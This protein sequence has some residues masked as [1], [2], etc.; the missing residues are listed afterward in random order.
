MSQRKKLIQSLVEGLSKSCIEQNRVLEELSA[1]IQ[2][3]DPL[4]EKVLLPICL[5]L[6]MCGRDSYVDASLLT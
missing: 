5:L 6:T 2:R 1:D 4:A 3:M